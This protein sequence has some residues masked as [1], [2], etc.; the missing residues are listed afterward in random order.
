M[1]DIFSELF[2]GQG[3]L[4]PGSKVMQIGLDQHDPTEAIQELMSTPMRMSVAIH[5][6][7]HYHSLS[8]PLGWLLAYLGYARAEAVQ[9]WDDVR[10]D[11]DRLKTALRTYELYKM[12]V[13]TVRSVMEGVA[14]F[15]QFCPPYRDSDD[16]PPSVST[17]ARIVATFEVLAPP[18]ATPSLL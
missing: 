7:A 16:L 1:S 5:E 4:E 2:L 18:A 12:V 11:P 17:L 8:N 15:S 6:L 3:K 14:V 10:T 13:E 9:A